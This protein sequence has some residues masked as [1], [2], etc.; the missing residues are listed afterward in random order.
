MLLVVRGRKGRCTMMRRS[1]KCLLAILGLVVLMP[2]RALSHCDGMDGPVVKSAQ[3]AL[4]GGNVNLVLIWVQKA[5]EVE[6]RKAFERTM[7]VRKL[8]LEV[9][10]WLIGIFLRRWCVC[11]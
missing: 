4:D 5:D 6:V 11:I 2:G 8:G 9:R 3:K 10:N 1:W 7:T